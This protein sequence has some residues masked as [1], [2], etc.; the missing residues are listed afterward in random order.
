MGCAYAEPNQFFLNDGTGHFAEV[1]AAAEPF[2]IG[3]GRGPEIGRGLAIGDVDN[4][5][6]IDILVSNLAGQAR[7]FVNV[8]RKQGHWL[9]IRVLE[10][11]LGGRDAYGAVVTLRA[12]NQ[13]WMR[14]VNPAFSYLSSNDPRVHFGLGEADKIDAISVLWADGVEELFPGV[15]RRPATHSAPR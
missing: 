12:G 9:Q 11:T 3:P 5:G 8:A 10:P 4:D 1:P 7:L 15:G 6:D 2:C 14:A 13:R